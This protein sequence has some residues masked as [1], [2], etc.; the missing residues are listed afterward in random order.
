MLFRNGKG[1]I[2][3]YWRE[4][5]PKIYDRALIEL[6]RKWFDTALAGAEI[7]VDSHFSTSKAIVWKM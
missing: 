6:E 3:K 7:L 4:Y 5:S 2:E 1:K